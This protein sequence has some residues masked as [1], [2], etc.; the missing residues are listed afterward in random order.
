M[1][2]HYGRYQTGR[3]IP[4]SALS[5]IIFFDMEA[6]EG[7]SKFSSQRN[8][9]HPLYMVHYHESKTEQEP[10]TQNSVMRIKQRVE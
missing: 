6:S 1:Y 5:D 2:Y 3:E 10:K 4:T 8:L 7:V 9:I